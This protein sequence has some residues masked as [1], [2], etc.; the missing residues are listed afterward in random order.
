MSKK[1]ELVKNEMGAYPCKAC[2]KKQITSYPIIKTVADLAY[3]QF[4]NPECSKYDPY[5]FIGSTK[6]GAILNWNESMVHDYDSYDKR[7]K[8]KKF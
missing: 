1:D 4:S 5:E 2:L 7:D 3:A 8:N 6:K